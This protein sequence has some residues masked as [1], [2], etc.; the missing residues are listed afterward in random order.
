MH[1]IGI[2]FAVSLLAATPRAADETSAVMAVVSQFTDAFNKG[3]TKTAAGA[4]AD[5]TFIIDEFPPYAWHGAGA[6]LTWMGDWDADAKKNGIAD[7]VVTL[8]KPKHVDVS[9]DR[10]Y[11]VVPADYAY[12]MKGKAVKETGSILTAALHKEAAGWR[13]T[14][15]TWAKN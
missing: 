6:C 9:V 3:D 7:A 5:E 15:W 8:S 11:V 2:A 4:C 14:A 13:I 10:A 12:K 1:K